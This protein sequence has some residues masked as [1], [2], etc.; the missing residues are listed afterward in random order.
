[1]CTWLAVETIGYFTRN[2]AEVFT[3]QTDKTKAFDLVQHSILFEK[4]RNKKMAK[5]FL[6]LIMIMYLNQ[7]AQVR[8]NGRLSDTFKLKNGCKQGAVLSGLLYNF[9]VNS[10]FQRLR[11]RKDGCWVGL[12]YVGMVGYADDDWLLAPSLHALQEMLNTCEEFNKEHG[13][14]F[15][16]DSNPAKSKTKCIYCLYQKTEGL[17]TNVPLWK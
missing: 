6:R 13:L 15:S 10:L 11:E 17:E 1:M 9:Y 16:T 14:I 7:F 5:L 12:K 8:W 3:C 2:G 4:L